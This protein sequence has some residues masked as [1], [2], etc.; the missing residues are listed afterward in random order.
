VHE[1]G[2]APSAAAIWSLIGA[3]TS[4]NGSSSALKLSDSSNAAM[5]CATK[6]LSLAATRKPSRR[7][8]AFAIAI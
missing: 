2:D 1:R 3:R 8:S 6:W 7:T 5:R 4:N